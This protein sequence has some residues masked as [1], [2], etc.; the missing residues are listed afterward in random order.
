MYCR[1]SINPKLNN[2]LAKGLKN[3]PRRLF[4]GESEGFVSIYDTN[5]VFKAG[6]VFIYSFFSRRSCLI[7]LPLTIVFAVHSVFGE[8]LSGHS[9]NPATQSAT[10]LPTLA[11]CVWWRSEGSGLP[12]LTTVTRAKGH[13]AM[14]TALLPCF[15]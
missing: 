3:L 7:Q 9:R 8:M 6:F 5:D 4:P 14:Q 15:I 10:R 2:L 13:F 11:V 1:Y 12:P